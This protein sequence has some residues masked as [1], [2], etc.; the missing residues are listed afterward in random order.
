LSSD[1]SLHRLYICCIMRTALFCLILCFISSRLPAQQKSNRGKEFWLGY[2]HNI[3]FTYPEAGVVNSQQLAIYIS[4][5]ESATVTVSV[6]GTGFSQTV[7]IPANAVDASILIPK[8]GP[9]DARITAEGITNRGIHIQSTVPIV[10]YAHQYGAVSSAATML[11]PVETFG[12][13][14]YSLNFAQTTNYGVAYSWFYAVASENNTRLQIT[15]SDTTENGWLPGNTYTVNLQKGEIYN[16]FGKR[17]AN[18]STGKDLTGSKII[19]IVGSDGN[20][21]PVGVFCGSSRNVL[22]S[23]NCTGT[24]PNGSVGNGNGGEILM[25]QMLP[26]NA[27]G[28]KYITY[29]TINNIVG[30]IQTPF[31]NLYRIAVR[32]PNTIVKRNGQVLSNLQRGFY[33]EFRDSAGSVIE[34]NQPILVAQ[35][36]VNSRECLSVQEDN[37]LGDP[38]MIYVSPI[39]QGIKKIILF[40][41]RREAINVSMINII[42]PTAA[43]NSLLIDGTGPTASESLPHPIDPNYSVVARRYLGAAGFRTVTCQEPFIATVYGVGPS[44]SYG[45]NAGTLVNN[46]N[47][48]TSFKNKF[49][50]EI[51]DSVTCPKAPIELT[52]QLAYKASQIQWRFSQVGGGIN[53]SVDRIDNNPIPT[54]STW[55]N[56]RRYYVY[57]SNTSYTFSQPGQY[58]IPVTYAA[59]DLDACNQTETIYIDIRVGNG[60]RADFSIQGKACVGEPISLNGTPQAN[61]FNLNAYRWQFSDNSTANT[62]NTSKTFTTSG[63][64]PISFTVFATNGCVHDTIKSIQIE[65]VPTAQI[66]ISANSYCNGKPILFEAATTGIISQWIWDL[67]DGN[68]N[69]VPPFNHTYLQSGTFN[70]SLQ[71]SSPNG[72]LSTLDQEAI[73]IGSTPLVN[74]GPDLVIKKGESTTLLGT[75]SNSGN[76]SVVWTPNLQ[77]SQDNILQPVASPTRTTTYLL[78][79]TDRLR[80]CTAQDSMQVQ[81][82]TQLAI[83]N[84]FSPNRDGHND[85]WEL[86]GIALYPNAVV[87]IYNRWGQKIFSTAQYERNPWDGTLQGIIQPNGI[88]VYVIQLN[89]TEKEVLRGNLVLVR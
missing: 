38:E 34:A 87:S 62:L 42:V 51:A 63:T 54:D 5:E 58:Q 56:G 24:F 73:V 21:H 70:T 84:A 80:N 64:Q 77:L 79:A 31:L 55:I 4:T 83:P 53:P 43:L 66:Q 46:L 26:A 60:P 44:E 41:A 72:C 27:W 28:T 85:V 14:Y 74:A 20:C 65:A 17:N 19:S 11:M 68:S 13:T 2:G 6:N 48:F 61:G 35:Y 25:Q 81:V 69:Q 36:P 29:H 39:E 89:N 10:A 49:G 1:N 9:N 71:V 78:R 32:N 52:L 86:P 75:I 33:Y 59:A 8:T 30:D 40:N 47:A 23:S 45:Y 82:I 50:T 15:P 67:G 37:P 18:G 22:L 76:Y 88:Y 3:L 12:Y 57:T 16:V 7:T